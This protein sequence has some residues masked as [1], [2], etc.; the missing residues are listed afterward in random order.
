[1]EKLIYEARTMEQLFRAYGF[2]QNRINQEDRK[3]TQEQGAAAADGSGTAAAGNV[4]RRRGCGAYSGTDDSRMAVKK[5]AVFPPFF[6]FL[7]SKTPRYSVIIVE[8]DKRRK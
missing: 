2:E 4:Q 1:M 6:L 5:T 7:V 3:Q 8:N